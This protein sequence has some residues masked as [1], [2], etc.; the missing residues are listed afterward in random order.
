MSI[1]LGQILLILLLSLLFFGNVPKLLRDLAFGLKEAK[2]VLREGEDSSGKK[3][4]I[5]ENE[6]KE[7][8]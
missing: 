5:K 6:K 7:K 3:L 8:E 4:A 1:G 2:K